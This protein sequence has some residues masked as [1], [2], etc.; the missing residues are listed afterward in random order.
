MGCNY[1]YTCCVFVVDCLFV[2]NVW[3]WGMRVVCKGVWGV[4]GVLGG[5][6]LGWVLVAFW[7]LFFLP[8]SHT[9]QWPTFTNTCSGPDKKKKKKKKKTSQQNFGP[10]S[11]LKTTPPFAIKSTDWPIEIPINSIFPGFFMALLTR[12]NHCNGFLFESGPWQMRVEGLYVN[13]DRFLHTY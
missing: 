5:C 6:V 13:F 4:V 10:P 8:K 7:W 3:A 2:V 9:N 11:W 1:V 12:V